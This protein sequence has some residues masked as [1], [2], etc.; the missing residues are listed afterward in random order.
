MP[1]NFMRHVPEPLGPPLLQLVA[2][3]FWKTSGPVLHVAEPQWHQMRNSS[4]EKHGITAAWADGTQKDSWSE[5]ETSWS[6]RAPLTRASTC[7]LV[8]TV[9]CP[10]TSCWWIQRE[11]WVCQRAK[12][13]QR[14]ANNKGFPHSWLLICC[15]RHT[16]PNQRHVVWQHQPPYC[17]PPEEWAAYCCGREWT[18]PQTGGQE[19]TVNRLLLQ[20]MVSMQ[21]TVEMQKNIEKNRY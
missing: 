15:G 11:W 16:G 12:P 9:A 17:I 4:V 13:L 2:P 14:E 7:W 6:G 1:W 20:E 3:R 10:N 8:C 18:A 19:K 5:T 21:N